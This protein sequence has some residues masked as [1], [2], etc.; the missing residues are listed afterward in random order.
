MSTT[1]QK[2]A[3]P[4]PK[5]T[6]LALPTWQQAMALALAFIES[7]MEQLVRIRIDDKNWSDSDV[8]VVCG[9]DLALAHIKRLRTDMPTDH[10]R[11]DAEWFKAAAAINLSLRVFSRPDSYYFRQLESV[12]RQCDVLVDAVQFA[13]EE[14]CDDK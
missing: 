7:S 4:C 1:T 2:Q 3:K 9:V 10:A 12:K 6:P 11:F 13:K 8:D 5:A 14:A